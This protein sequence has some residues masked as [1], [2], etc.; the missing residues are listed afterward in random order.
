MVVGGW[1][2]HR[3][4]FGRSAGAAES[5]NALLCFF[6]QNQRL[7]VHG[8]L[9]P[10]GGRHEMGRSEDDDRVLPG[11]LLV[12]LVVLVLVVGV[13]DGADSVAVERQSRRE[14]GRRR[15]VMVVVAQ[16]MRRMVVNENA[17]RRSRRPPPP[18]REIA[19]HLLVVGRGAINAAGRRDV[20]TW[21]MMQPRLFCSP[22]S[23]KMLVRNYS[24][25][26]GNILLLYLYATC[27][28]LIW[29]LFLAIIVLAVSP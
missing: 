12:V 18:G 28:L 7:Q 21:V 2:D 25:W 29:P 10:T 17:G 27:I 14:A 16:W 20:E 11:P 23:K 13:A 9:D 26:T 5:V 6:S 24:R 8:A 1:A 22:E 19:G 3:W 4:Y 15:S